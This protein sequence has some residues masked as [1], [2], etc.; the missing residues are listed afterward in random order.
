MQTT[1]NAM[2][3]FIATRAPIQPTVVEATAASTMIVVS[4]P[5]MVCA[6]SPFTA[7]LVQ[8]KLTVKVLVVVLCHQTVILA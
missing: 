3:L 6:M 4:M 8:I 2:S 5:M 1:A 7:S